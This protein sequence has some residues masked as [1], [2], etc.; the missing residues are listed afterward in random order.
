MSG[1]AFRYRLKVLSATVSTDL[2]LF[3]V[4]SGSICDALPR[5]GVMIFGCPFVDEDFDFAVMRN[6]GFAHGSTYR[7]FHKSL[8]T[9]SCQLH[10][11]IV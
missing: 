8:A 1:Y 10:V 4:E 6:F 5:E 3:D 2:R 9:L 11:E 7:V